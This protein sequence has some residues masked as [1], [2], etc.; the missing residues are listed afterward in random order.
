MRPKWLRSL[1]YRHCDL[2]VDEAFAQKDR[3]PRFVAR[4][5]FSPLLHYTNEVTRYKKDPATGV[6]QIKHEQRPIKYASHP[7]P[8]SWP[9]MPFS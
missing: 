1:W 3:E 7:M 5:S 9:T 8:E 2:P 4:H 6:R